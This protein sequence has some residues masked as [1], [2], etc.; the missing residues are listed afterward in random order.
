MLLALVAAAQPFSRR[1]GGSVTVILDRGLSMS[2]TPD[3]KP[4]FVE[5]AERLAPYLS[6]TATIHLI[7][8]LGHATEQLNGS[9][10]LDV[11]RSKPFTAIDTKTLMSAAVAQTLAD[12][13]DPV[14][15]L[16]DQTIGLQNPRL[17][18][19]GPTHA[20]QDVGIVTVAARASP[21]MQ[22]M[23]SVRNQSRADQCILSIHSGEKTVQRKIDL[24]ARGHVANYFIDLPS[25]EDTVEA[26]ISMQDDLTADDAAWLVRGVQP[27]RIEIRGLVGDA[28]QRMVQVYSHVKPPNAD[29]PTAAIVNATDQLS[30]GDAGVVVPP[31][32]HALAAGELRVTPDPLTKVVNWN[33]AI[34]GA[35]VSK[36]PDGDWTPLVTVGNSVLLAKRT[37]PARQVWVGFSQQAWPKS[38]DFVVFWTNV[39]NWV[40]GDAVQWTAMPVQQLSANWK[41]IASPPSNVQPNAW[42][43]IYRNGEALLAM[44]SDV[45]IFSSDATAPLN[46]HLPPGTSNHSWSPYFLI[47]AIGCG[48]LAV[49]TMPRRRGFHSSL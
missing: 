35:S 11:I 32:D 41:A 46:L 36:P 48:I 20:V 2:A 27:M 18:V 33:A 43:G 4:R 9:A 19:I 42:P 31:P 5:T 40:A 22:V 25:L 6:N 14:I 10:W 47:A 21:A 1:L 23:V 12:G 49:A 15:V 29:A 13:Q 45:P 37:S 24:P 3:G 7:D 38:P 30:A 44:N 8:P 16:T 34:G 17:T 26:Q 28:L 39:L